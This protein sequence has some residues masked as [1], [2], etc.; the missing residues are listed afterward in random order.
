MKNFN[1]M[2]GLDVFVANNIT[3]TTELHNLQYA[4]SKSS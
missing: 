1:C 4:S 2:H 3:Y